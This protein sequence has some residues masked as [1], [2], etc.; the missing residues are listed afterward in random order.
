MEQWHRSQSIVVPAERRGESD[1]DLHRSATVAEAVRLR[2]DRVADG[3]GGRQQL[4]IESRRC[5]RV[6]DGPRCVDGLAAGDDP[7]G[8]P[9]GDENPFYR[10]AG[11]DVHAQ[12]NEQ[13]AKCF[14]EAAGPPGD[15]G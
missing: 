15:N 7:R 9:V 4:P 2:A 10:A 3:G 13:R 1:V 12:L 8:A 11:A 6:E 5:H 14:D